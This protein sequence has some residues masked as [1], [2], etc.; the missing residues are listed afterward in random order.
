VTPSFSYSSAAISLFSAAANLSS[1]TAAKLLHFDCG[2]MLF[3]DGSELLFFHSDFNLRD[4]HV[5]FS[6]LRLVSLFFEH[7]SHV[8]DELLFKLIEFLA[9]AFEYCE[10]VIVSSI[11]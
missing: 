4:K 5:L 2:A 7:N 6:I 3:F 1:S 9:P 11:R 10:R 8:F